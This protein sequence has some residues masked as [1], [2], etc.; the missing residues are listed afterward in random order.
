MKCQESNIL[1][2]EGGGGGEA[3][4]GGGVGGLTERT[5]GVV[6]T[7]CCLST[8]LLVPSVRQVPAAFRFK[9]FGQV[10]SL[11]DLNQ[12][13]QGSQASGRARAGRVPR[14][15]WS[16]GVAPARAEGAGPNSPVKWASRRAPLAGW[17][18]GLTKHVA[19][20]YLRS[21]RV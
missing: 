16:P 6:S 2:S 18:S 17:L 3:L 21:R 20:V 11:K 15:D 10:A 7:A 19:V 5:V 8:L 13:H 1:W 14:S 4:G 12:S 9:A